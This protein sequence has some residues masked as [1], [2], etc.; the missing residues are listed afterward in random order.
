MALN[1]LA[2]LKSIGASANAFCIAWFKA[3][4]C[5][6]LLLLPLSVDWELVILT[7]LCS[8]LLHSVDDI[9]VAVALFGASNGYTVLSPPL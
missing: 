2:F 8:L 9:S 7:L 5:S 6:A 1:F 3:C 4:S